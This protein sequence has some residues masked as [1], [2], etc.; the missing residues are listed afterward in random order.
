MTASAP[1]S[2]AAPPTI[3]HQVRNAPNARRQLPDPPQT[4]RGTINDITKM[5]AN[6]LAA[7]TR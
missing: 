7:F 6:T 2:R 1:T 4:M 5:A 3:S